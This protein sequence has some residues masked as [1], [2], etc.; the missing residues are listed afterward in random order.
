M[1]TIKTLT[2]VEMIKR[3]IESDYKAKFVGKKEPFIMK[4]GTK[5]FNSDGSNP[6]LFHLDDDKFFELT[7]FTL[8]YEWVEVNGKQEELEKIEQEMKKLASKLEKLRKEL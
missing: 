3:W 8:G 1:P 5:I 6:N 7:E 2:T 4:V